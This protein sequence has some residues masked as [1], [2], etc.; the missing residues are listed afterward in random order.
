MNLLDKRD[1]LLAQIHRI[2]YRM[3]EIKYVKLI[4]ERDIRAE[5]GGLLERLKSAQGIKIAI[6]QHEMAELQ[7]D[8]DMINDLGAMFNEYT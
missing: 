5:Y 1:Q 7:K 6:L 3:E 2:E 4:I 8:S